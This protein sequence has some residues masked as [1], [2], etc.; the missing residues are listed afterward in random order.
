MSMKV[1]IVDTDWR[2][3]GQAM[4]YLESHA[5][6][7]VHEA[8]PQAA[9]EKAK[10]WRPDMVI[11][12]AE[13]A[14]K[15]MHSLY[16]MNPRPAVMLTSWMDRYDLAWRAWQTGGDELLMKPVLTE[17]D[18]QLAVLATLENAAAGGRAVRTHAA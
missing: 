5:H 15:L 2:F 11:L 7:A 9:L 10:S 3:A 14:D 17:D 12:A 4:G 8:D 18:L 13:M 6:L 16:A 1:M